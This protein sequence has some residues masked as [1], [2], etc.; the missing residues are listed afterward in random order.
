MKQLTALGYTWVSIPSSD[1]EPLQLLEQ[2]GAGQVQQ[3]NAELTDMF[4]P[5]NY[6]PPLLQSNKP[7]P[8]SLHLQEEVDVQVDAN[9]GLLESFVKI[10]TGKAGLHLNID[11]KKK[12]QFK[13]ENATKS[14]VNII[15][16]DAFI[17]DALV[18][19]M[20]STFVAKLKSDG[21]YVITEVIKASSF[22]LSFEK[23]SSVDT[24]IEV[25]TNVAEINAGYDRATG[26]L[27]VMTSQGAA[28]LTV[29]VRAARIFFDKPGFLSGKPAKFR[30]NNDAKVEVFKGEEEYP[31]SY[32]DKPFVTIITK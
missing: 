32:L 22:V 9:L 12:L 24:G 4:E 18:N 29:A 1:I 31:A 3:L 25:P 14:V 8:S 30:L 10:F 23:N 17:Q 26:E 16:L 6:A 5:K 20:A 7:L 27:R 19:D 28:P 11:K 2:V 21:L 13:L 15:K